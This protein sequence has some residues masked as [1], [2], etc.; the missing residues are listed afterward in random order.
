MPVFQKPERIVLVHSE[1]TEEIQTPAITLLICEAIVFLITQ[2]R[3]S[4]YIHRYV[5]IT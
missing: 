1:P 2:G 3:V 5:D 4:W